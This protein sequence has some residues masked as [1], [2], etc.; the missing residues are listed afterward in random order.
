ML[1]TLEIS[2]IT[3]IM[4]TWADGMND[5]SEHK[6]NI[7]VITS[8]NFQNVHGA[9]PT[10]LS[11]F[12]DV[13]D[14]LSNE[15]FVITGNFSTEPNKRTNIVRI[16]G[17]EKTKSMLIRTP[18]FIMTQI[19]ISYNLIKIR[20]K[21]DIV[22]FFLGARTYLLPML[23]LKLLKKKTVLIAVGSIINVTKIQLVQKIFGMRKFIYLYIPR[24]LGKLNYTLSDKIIVYSENLI[25]KLELNEYIKKISS[26]GAR[27]VDTS[28]FDVKIDLQK[29]KILI[30]YIGRLSPE[31][32]VANFAKAIPLILGERDSL[33]FLI[34]G[35]GPLFAE[36]SNELKN[37]GSYN[38][39]KLTGW[40][41]HD[42]LPDYLNELKLLV[43]PSYTE[44][45]PNI[46]LEVMACGTPVLATPVGGVPDMIKDGVTGFILEDNSP[47][48]IAKNVVRALEH[49]DLDEIVKNARE[50]VE[51]EYTYEDAVERYRKIL[52]NI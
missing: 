13:L 30:G 28:L 27:Y 18:K 40:I 45:L 12:V 4:R 36:I 7:C 41:L 2:M 22:I 1:L 5:L 14:P 35:D 11:N 52:E 29:R 6:L 20:K 50:L 16:K 48:C 51:K 46:I 25:D 24:I 33:E 8:P 19:R 43:L 39:V 47:E 21:V 17:D 49:P 26:S 23:L 10:I 32:G 42:K 34:G 9:T 31:K 38:K 37:N 44:G 15:L 3:A